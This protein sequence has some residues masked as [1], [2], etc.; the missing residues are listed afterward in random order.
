LLTS[1]V[2]ISVADDYP[3]HDAA[4]LMPRPTAEQLAALEIDIDANGQHEPVTTY[5]K[6]ILDGLSRQAICKKLGRPLQS[7][8]YIGDR[9]FEYSWSKNGPRRHLSASQLAMLSTVIPGLTH[10]GNRKSKDQVEQIPLDPGP[11][12]TEPMSRAEKAKIFGVSD[13]LIQQAEVLKRYGAAELILSV[14][15]GEISIAEALKIVENEIV[16]DK[17]RKALAKLQAVAAKARSKSHQAS[18]PPTVSTPAT[19]PKTA[20]DNK[21]AG[22]APAPM[23]RSFNAPHEPHTAVARRLNGSGADQPVSTVGVRR[24]TAD[25]FKQELREFILS[26]ESRGL[27]K[28]LREAGDV[29]I[30]DRDH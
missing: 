11:E 10:G 5:K 7:R 8:E 22:V 21:V 18:P 14:R 4:L 6:T 19:E 12:K 23:S 17:Q 9:P 1:N 2:E 20:V 3:P 15:S 24:L 27:T 13:K 30:A 25:G 28:A 16:A 29:P 26:V